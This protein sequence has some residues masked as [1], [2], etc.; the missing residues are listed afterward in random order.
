MGVLKGEKAMTFKHKVI[1]GREWNLE[2]DT[3]VMW[4]QMDDCIRW[5]GKEALGGLQGKRNSDIDTM[6]TYKISWEQE[7]RYFKLALMKKRKSNN[8]NHLRCI[9]SDNKKVLVKGN[10]IKERWREYFNKLL[11]EDSIESLRTRKDTFV[12]WTY[13]LLQN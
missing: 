8:L 11:N 3:K 13:F 9:K 6:I 5:V 2:G 1:K 10:D 4:N 7:E 12:N